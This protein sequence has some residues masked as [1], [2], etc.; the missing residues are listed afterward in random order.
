MSKT[1]PTDINFPLDSIGFPCQHLSLLPP[2]HMVGPLLNDS[3]C[4]QLTINTECPTTSTI[5]HMLPPPSYP[6]PSHIMSCTHYLSPSARQWPIYPQ[7]DQANLPS[8]ST[9]SSHDNLLLPSN[10]REFDSYILSMPTSNS[11]LMSGSLEGPSQIRPHPST[12]NLHHE[13]Q[14]WMHQ[15]MSQTHIFF[16]PMDVLNVRP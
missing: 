8:S 12:I 9:I 10:T 14:D 16:S 1:D 2:N 15:S 13:L 7:Q 3:R 5:T 4:I 6:S 11:S